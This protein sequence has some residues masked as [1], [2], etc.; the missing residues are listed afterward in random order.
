MYASMVFCAY[1]SSVHWSLY[2]FFYASR[3]L[4]LLTKLFSHNIPARRRQQQALY[5]FIHT[6][7]IM[8]QPSFSPSS[9]AQ[10]QLERKITELH[11]KQYLPQEL[12][13][14]MA[15]VSRIQLA[16]EESID[17]GLGQPHVLPVSLPITTPSR[18]AQGEPVLLREYFPLDTIGLPIIA[19][20]IF[21]VLSSIS[22]DL[23]RFAEKLQKLLNDNTYSL[24][25]ACRAVVKAPISLDEGSYFY[26][27]AKNNPGASYLFSFLAASCVLPSVKVAGRLLAQHHDSSAVWG[28]G[29]CPVCGSLPLMGRL[30]ETEGFRL[31]TCSFCLHEFK[32]TRMACPFCLST[33]EE[34][35]NYF[36]SED[37]PG[38]QLHVCHDCKSYC[39]IADFRAFD[40][41]FLPVLDDLGSLVLDLYGRKQGFLRPTL[42]VWG[43]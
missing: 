4:H 3:L 31:H 43:T 24:E 36:I 6:D 29:H 30:V 8:T 28:H 41:V 16:A 32:A 23:E 7:G 21:P 17:F 13:T 18:H 37:E 25:E 10:K 19:Q 2:V 20:K 11:K 42:S 15:E 22:P 27:W 12:V 38:Y 9:I 40:R 1:W 34:K 35:D 33:G 14:L 39:K 5:S 26:D